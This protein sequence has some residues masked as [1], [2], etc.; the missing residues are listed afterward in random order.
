MKVL[1]VV[2]EI[3]GNFSYIIKLDEFRTNDHLM[4]KIF[5]DADFLCFQV[6]FLILMLGFDHMDPMY[7]PLKY[8]ASLPFP[9]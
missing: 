9:V 8:S 3:G 5:M 4:V 2:E 1:V 7:Y 6:T